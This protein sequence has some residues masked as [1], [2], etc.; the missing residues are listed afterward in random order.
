M[1][2]LTCTY[3][4]WEFVAWYVGASMRVATVTQADTKDVRIFSRR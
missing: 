4:I 3:Q 1:V 2:N